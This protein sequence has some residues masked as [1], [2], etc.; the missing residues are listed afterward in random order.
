MEFANKHQAD[1]YAAYLRMGSK[2]RN[3]V[4][5]KNGVTGASANFYCKGVPV[6][7]FVREHYAGDWVNALDE[8]QKHEDEARVLANA[9]AYALGRK[10]DNLIVDALA[11][12]SRCLEHYDTGLNIEKAITVIDEFKRE[13]VPDDGDRFAIVGWKQWSELLQIDRKSVV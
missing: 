10:T 9:G 6:R 12:V 3:T 5:V 11:N 8:A 4:L 1:V 13:D 7:C 2:L